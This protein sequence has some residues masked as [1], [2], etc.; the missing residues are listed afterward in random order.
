MGIL[1][2]HLHTC[3]PAPGE[4][5]GE[6]AELPQGLGRRRSELAPRQGWGRGRGLQ[7]RAEELL[8]Q[9]SCLPPGL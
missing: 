1:P 6:R 8:A 3:L 7:V 5:A 4:R 9:V 2:T